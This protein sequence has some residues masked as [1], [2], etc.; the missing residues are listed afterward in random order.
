MKPWIVVAVLLLSSCAGHQYA[1]NEGPPRVS[2]KVE[3]YFAVVEKPWTW[4]ILIEGEIDAYQD[5]EIAVVYT[6]YRRE[7][8][9]TVS[10]FQGLKRVHQITS[11]FET[12]YYL[13]LVGRPPYSSEDEFWNRHPETDPREMEP[14][15]GYDNYFSGK[16][17]IK[18]DIWT[19]DTYEPAIQQIEF[20]EH[21]GTAYAR[22]QFD[23]FT[24]RI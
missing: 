14:I 9:P 7:Q 6:T 16:F 10:V 3:K 11:K 23:C 24:C 5:Q 19:V 21:I 4:W 13:E 8:F 17:W 18:V 20:G 15:E 1:L 12:R 22:G 2:V